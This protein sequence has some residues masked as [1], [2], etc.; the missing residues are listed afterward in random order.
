MI[1]FLNAVGFWSGWVG[2]PGV[3]ACLGDRDGVY[4]PRVSQSGQEI[5]EPLRLLKGTVFVQA[6]QVSINLLQFGKK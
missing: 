2:V 4:W 1:G 6:T 3:Y 5:P